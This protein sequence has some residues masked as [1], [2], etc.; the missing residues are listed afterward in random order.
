MIIAIVAIS[1]RVPLIVLD[2]DIIK[3]PLFL[4][5]EVLFLN[6]FYPGS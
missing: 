1:D 6:E 2:Q 3:S 4:F 5:G